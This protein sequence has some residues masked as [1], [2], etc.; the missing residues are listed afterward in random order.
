M[1]LTISGSATS[2]RIAPAAKNERPNTTPPELRLRKPSAGLE[3]TT[4][5]NSASTIDGVPATISTADSVSRASANGR[6]Y[7]L[8]HTAVATPSGS[9]IAIAI[10]ATSSVPSSGSRKPPVW[11]S[12]KPAVGWVTS[13]L[14]RT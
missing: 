14:G 2:D 11:V 7:S 10:A 1:L 9:A 4:V 13:R 12:L 3:K 6:P 8:S 5:P